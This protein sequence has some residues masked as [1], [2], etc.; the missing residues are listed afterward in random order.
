MGVPT[1]VIKR[2]QTTGAKWIS[3]HLYAAGCGCWEL[4]SSSE[5]QQQALLTDEPS[6]YLMSFIT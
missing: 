1:E 2:H 6:L 5:E 4:N 3:R